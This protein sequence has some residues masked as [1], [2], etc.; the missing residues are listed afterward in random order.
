MF[1]QAEQH[2]HLRRRSR[3]TTTTSRTSEV[4]QAIS[5]AID[6]QAII[7]AV[8][9]GRFRAGD[10][11]R[12]PELRR[13]PRRRL[14]ST[15][16]WTWPRPRRCWPRPAAGRAASSSSGPTPVPVTTSGCRPFGDQLKAN[17]GIDYELQGQPAVRRSTWRPPTPRSSPARSASAGAR[18]T[19]CSRPTSRRCTAPAARRTTPAT[20]NPQFDDLIK[21]G[22]ARQDLDE[23]HRRSTSRPRTSSCEDLPVIPMWFGKAAAVYSENVDKFVCTTRIS[24]ADY[25]QIDAE[26]VTSDRPMI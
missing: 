6:R 15:A 19:R 22:D 14:H 26:E 1:E 17:L 9:D 2:L 12:E 4:R 16:S 10:R 21:Q 18:T 3:C 25:G 8:F 20:R 11:R 5:M 7:D 13:L 24:D 23:A